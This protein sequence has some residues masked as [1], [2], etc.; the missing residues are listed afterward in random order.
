M[1]IC[2]SSSAAEVARDDGSVPQKAPATGLVQRTPSFQHM[3]A[4]PSPTTNPAHT[5]ARAIPVAAP[6]APAGKSRKVS[7]TWRLCV[8]CARETRR[9]R[10]RAGGSAREP[11]APR[12]ARARAH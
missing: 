11:R 5:S 3:P 7:E 9:R 2:A 8:A 10:W 12:R 1:G 4:Q 6:P